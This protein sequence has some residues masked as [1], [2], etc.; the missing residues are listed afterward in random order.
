MENT[1]WDF[2]T[3]Q[4]FVLIYAS[5]ADME[6]TD[7]E[8]AQI[9]KSISPKKFEELYAQF[10]NLTDYQ[11]LELILSYKEKY[12]STQAEKEH[13]LNEM[14][15]LFNADGEYSSLEKELLMFLNKLL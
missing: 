10:N 12:F 6:F 14:K 15:K 13:L 4:A 8:K 5:H 9:K 1:N 3:F 7:D 11:V 2:N